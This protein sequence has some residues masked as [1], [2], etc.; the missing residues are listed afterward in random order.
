M[1]SEEPNDASIDISGYLSTYTKSLKYD[2][3]VKILKNTI[4]ECNH[5][6]ISKGTAQRAKDKISN[7]RHKFNFCFVNMKYKHSTPGLY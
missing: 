5:K 2:K 3:C 4:K 7:G 1:K 6:N